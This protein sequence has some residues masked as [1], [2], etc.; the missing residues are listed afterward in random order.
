[1]SL[2]R[3]RRTFLAELGKTGAALAAGSW[4][5][6]L[7]LCAD[8]GRSGARRDQPGALPVGPRS[9]AVRRVPRTPRARDLHRRLRPGLAAGRRAG[10]PQGRHRGGG[11]PAR[12]DHAVPGRQH[13]LG[14]QLVGRRRPEERRPDRA[15][16]RLELDRDQPVRHQRFHRLG[17]AGRHR[18]AARLQP[19]HRHVG[20]GRGLHRVLQL[21]QGH[22]VERPAP[23]ARLR[24]SRTR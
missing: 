8:A 3:S 11:G 7:G 1:M 22:Q 4:L 13:G 21:R 15:R 16:A 6:S 19:R 20:N 18:A 17:Q 2:T 5:S 10:L 9:P 12:A 14:L 23:L 24:R